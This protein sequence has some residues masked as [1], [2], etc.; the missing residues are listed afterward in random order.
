MA[1]TARIREAIGQDNEF[2]FI[3]GHIHA[4]VVLSLST[5]FTIL[6]ATVTSVLF[7]SLTSRST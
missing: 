5:N 3:N 1:T 4:D 6:T 7:S 2:I